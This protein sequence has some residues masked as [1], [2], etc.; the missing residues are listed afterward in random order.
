MM[1]LESL[2][3]GGT[4]D[5][6]IVNPEHVTHIEP[7]TEDTCSVFMLGGHKLDITASASDVARRLGGDRSFKLG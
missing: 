2:P 7:L 4:R 6:Y 1:T 3:R 5:P